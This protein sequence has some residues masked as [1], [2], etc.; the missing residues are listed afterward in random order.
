MPEIRTMTLTARQPLSLG[1]RH[2][3]GTALLR[4]HRHV[5]GT[6]LRGALA[7]AWI[8]EH[9]RPD[10]L[11][12]SDPALLAQFVELFERHVRYGALFLDGWA[13]LPL[14]VLRCKYRSE[15]ACAR[16]HADEAFGDGPT[17]ECGACGGPAESAKGEIESFG[18]WAGPLLRQSTHVEL[19]ADGVAAEGQL[20][21]REAIRARDDHGRTTTLSGELVVPDDLSAAARDWLTAE[22][23]VR[24]G[25][26]GSTSGLATLAIGPATPELAQPTARRL[27]L[28]FTAPALLVDGAGLPVLRP[29]EPELAELLGTAVTIERSWARHERIGGWN[30]AT[31]LPKPEEPAVSAGSTYLLHC[32]E[33]PDAKRLRRLCDSG[34]GLRRNE[35]YGSLR[36]DTEPWSPPS[37]RTPTG[38]GA[39]QVDEN[40]EA[41]ARTAALL[42]ATG[43][44]PWLLD[45]LRSYAR[46]RAASGRPPH[47]DLLAATTLRDLRP[48]D[49]SA[50]ERLLLDPE[51]SALD[52][53]LR[54]LNVLVRRG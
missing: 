25:G 34:L 8:T 22:H 39:S 40:T 16:W 13:L 48:S 41:P 23:R 17:E 7:Q 47:T 32:A 14:S 11:A 12:G 46:D 31:N 10:E 30:R 20:F 6:V 51:L 33:V 43:H 4:S 36:I 54:H 38:D 3:P 42:Q 26:R 9:G 50:L 19:T 53:V 27:A 21:A 35:G 37:G 28:R 44:G 24:V 18:E 15:P 1:T 29:S 2:N 49:R 45:K 52:E 5:R